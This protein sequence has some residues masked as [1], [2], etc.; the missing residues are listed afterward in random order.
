MKKIYKYMPIREMLFQHPSLRGSQRGVLNDPFELNPAQELYDHLIKNSNDH[1]RLFERADELSARNSLTDIGV[2][3]FTENYNNLLMW[4]HYA[5]EHKGMVVEFDYQKL[6]NYFNSKLITD[7]SIGRVRYNSERT[8]TIHSEIDVSDILLSKG[9]DWI[10]EKEHRILP[11]LINAD[12][13]IVKSEIFEQCHDFYDDLYINLFHVKEKKDGLVKFEV[14]I[15]ECERLDAKRND[16]SS[17]DDDEEMSFSH[18]ESVLNE[19]YTTLAVFPSTIFLFNFPLETIT[20]IFLGC[21]VPE[22]RVI[23]LKKIISQ[24][25]CVYKAELNKSRFALDFNL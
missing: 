13:V 20:S 5:D 19:I 4:S 18:S 10:Y 1:T 11:N 21:R 24:D 15:F 3:S 7:T 22:D 17:T 23:E 2:I 9:D 12:S 16:G 6:S 14:N 8:P 25:I